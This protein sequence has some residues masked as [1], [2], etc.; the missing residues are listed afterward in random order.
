MSD[1]LSTGISALLS[2]RKALDTTGHNIANVNTPGYTRQRVDLVSR[3]GG[4]T[5]DGYVGSGVEAATVRR[6]ADAFVGARAVSDTS[7]YRRAEQFEAVAAQLDSWMSDAATGPGQ[8]LNQFFDSLNA[9]AADPTSAAAR[10]TVLSDARGLTSRFRS[11]QGQLDSV[12]VE[13]NSRLRQSVQDINAAAQSIAT[14]NQRIAQAAAAAGGQPP[15]DLLDQRDALLQD[16]AGQIG[17]NTTT[18]D[19]GSINVFT[20]SGQALVLG[21]QSQALGVADD[22]YGSGR[23]EVTSSGGVVTGQLGGGALGGLLDAQR[24]VLDPA[25]AQLGRLAV[26]LTQAFNAQHQQG[27]DALGQD[28]GLF[29]NSIT[30]RALAADGNSGNAQIGVGF[31]DVGA[32]TGGDYLLRFDGANWQLSDATTGASISMSGSGAPGDP[33]V[34]Q[35]LSLTV[36]G[37]PAGQDRY[38]IRPTALA[39]GQMQMAISDPAN[40]AAAAAGSG[41]DSSDNGNARALLGLESQ[42]LLDSG[43]NSLQA[44]QEKLVAGI[45]NQARQAGIAR[46]AQQS[47]LA[48][49]VASRDAASG[50]N[51]DEEASDL[52]RFQ[53][54]Y[55]AAAQVIA[56][57]DTVFQSLLAA[58]RR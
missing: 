31:S 28:G 15:N 34:A 46:G 21:A 36:N 10:Q 32:L 25:L 52:V 33:L 11:L 2:Y 43:R 13:L 35:G 19:D 58:V 45:G 55:Q 27:V 9:L 54:A 29:F 12:Q 57:A 16:L 39:A 4:P 1:L 50:V 20:G 44:A 51:L 30:G 14:L 7:A 22:A 17:V 6:I 53:Q 8:P 41:A 5:G 38:L 56:V 47:L 48:Q 37:V 49:S 23:L 40:L 24:E 3:L 42:G 18:A 26:G